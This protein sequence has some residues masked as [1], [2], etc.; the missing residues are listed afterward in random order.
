MIPSPPL[1]PG[2]AEPVS[3]CITK[4]CKTSYYWVTP[5]EGPGTG[6]WELR[7]QSNFCAALA[8]DDNLWFVGVPFYDPTDGVYVLPATID[9]TNGLTSCTADGDC[10]A[11]Q[12]NPGS[13]MITCNITGHYFCDGASWSL[14]GADVNSCGYTDG[15][16]NVPCPITCGT[17]IEN[18]PL[19]WD[20][21]SCAS[22]D[23]YIWDLVTGCTFDYYVG[24]GDPPAPC[25]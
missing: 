3:C 14:T 25:P 23:A 5:V 1:I 21:V 16:A 8:P 15:F 9:A 11:P 20:Y 17:W 7:Q 18:D 10:V 22:I 4:F 19:N 24:A 6:I 2:L 12:P 13:P